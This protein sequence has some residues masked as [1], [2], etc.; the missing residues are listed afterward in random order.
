MPKN[1]APYSYK[2]DLKRLLLNYQ[3]IAVKLK[4]TKINWMFQKGEKESILAVQTNVHELYIVLGTLATMEVAQDIHSRLI[5]WLKSESDS[6]L[7]VSSP[8]F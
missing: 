5:S 6:L 2:T 7:L 3:S 1:T 4:Q 8:I